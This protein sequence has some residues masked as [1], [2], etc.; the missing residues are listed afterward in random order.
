[1]G[2]DNNPVTANLANPL[3]NSGQ[4]Q[5]DQYS[6]IEN[7]AGTRFGDTLVGD[8]Q[9][10]WIAGGQ[11]NDAL[12]GGSGNDTADYLY[13]RPYVATTSVT[14]S[15]AVAGAQN[16]GGAGTDTLANFENLRGTVFADSL[17]G[18]GVANILAGEDGNDSL[19]GGAGNDTLLGGAGNDN[20]VGN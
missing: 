1:S 18:N 17:T 4:A 10:N 15:L 13:D 3:A 16:T 8:T 14:V 19:V 11:G 2:A 5:N 20:I 7:L 12:D 6:S 9:D